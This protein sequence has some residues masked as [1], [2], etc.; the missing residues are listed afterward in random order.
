MQVKLTTIFHPQTD[1]QAQYT[2][3]TLEDMLRAC[4]INFKG[5]WDDH[6]PLIEFSYNNSYNFSIGMAPSES[7][8]HRR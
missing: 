3:K 5:G 6:L 7:L 2:I 1:E 4:V 8:C